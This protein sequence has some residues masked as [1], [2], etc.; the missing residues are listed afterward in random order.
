MTD[1]VTTIQCNH[2]KTPFVIRRSSLGKIG[3]IQYETD[4]VAI[5]D[6]TFYCRKC[7]ANTNTQLAVSLKKI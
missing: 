2:C 5:N 6:N 7:V 4:L 1:Q 3:R